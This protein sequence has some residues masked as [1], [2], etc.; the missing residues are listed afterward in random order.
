LN[1]NGN[2][3]DLRSGGTIYIDNDATLFLNDIVIEGLGDSGCGTIIFGNDNSQLHMS[4]VAV[5]L[6]SDYSTTIGGIYVEGPTT[7][8]MDNYN[9][10]FDQQSSLTVDGTTLWKD[11]L[12]KVVSGDILFGPPESN[13]LSLLNSGTI[14]A[15]ANGDMIRTATTQLGD[16][17]TTYEGDISN[18][19]VYINSIDHGP[20]NIFFSVTQTMSYNI[21]LGPHHKMYLQDDLTLNGSTWYIHFSRA[22]E[23]LL[24]I[25]AGKTVTLRDVVLKD[26][27]PDYVSFGD[28]NSKLVFGGGTILEL[29]DDF[30][31]T[32]QW[33][34]TGDC[35]IKG[36]ET[37]I[38]LGSGGI[39]DVYDSSSLTLEDLTISGL[40]ALSNN[41]RCR[42]N[43]GSIIIKDSELAMSDDY[44]FTIG[45]MRFEHDARLTGTKV[46]TYSTSMTSTIASESMIYVDH[47]TTFKYDPPV[48]NRYLLYMTDTTSKL[49]LNGCVLYSTPT[50]LILKRGMVLFDNYVTLSAEGLLQSEAI[51]LGDPVDADGIDDL[52]VNV[53]GGAYVETYGYVD[54]K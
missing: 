20:Y 47:G 7:W 22:N 19:Y 27:H 14:K 29:I 12:D 9:W 39:I 13:Y 38:T 28:V 37:K 41:M 42:T 3:L 16:E 32:H 25:D 51:A 50:G 8:Y 33:T 44:A 46:F 15:T 21:Y 43:D 35:K 31:L 26:F 1:G 36:F 18:L 48:A 53:L 40:S 34:F 5:V 2:I 11:S 23:P 45:S 30:V 54:M 4:N 52:I 6:A 24:Y 10:T 17:I 49:N